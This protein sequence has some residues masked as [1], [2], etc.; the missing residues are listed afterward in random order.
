MEMAKE[1]EK[2]VLKSVSNIMHVGI[3]LRL[4]RPTPKFKNHT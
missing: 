1:A 4:G 3:Q 2:E